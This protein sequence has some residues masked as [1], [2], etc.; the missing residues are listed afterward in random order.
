MPLSNA[1]GWHSAKRSCGS[2]PYNDLHS[3]DSIKMSAARR[4]HALCIA[5]L[6]RFIRWLIE[7]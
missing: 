3:W 2:T 6:D 4:T 7:R 5:L 1:E